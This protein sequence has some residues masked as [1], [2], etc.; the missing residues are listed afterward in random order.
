MLSMLRMS[1][2]SGRGRGQ[3]V[4]MSERVSQWQEYSLLVGVSDAENG[5]VCQF[6]A[7]AVAAGSFCFVPA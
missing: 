6:S 7:V 3:F 1:V 2:K 4:K 5:K